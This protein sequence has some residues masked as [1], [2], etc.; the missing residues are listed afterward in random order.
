MRARSARCWRASTWPAARLRAH[1]WTIRAASRGGAGAAPE[2]AALPRRGGRALLREEVDFQARQPPDALAARRDPR[3]S[4][5][6]Q[7]AVRGR[8]HRGRH[9]LLFR[10]H[11]RAA[12]RRRHHRQRLVRRARTA[13]STTARARALLD[14]YRAVRPFTAAER[15][16]WPAMLRA[17]ALRFWVS[18][19][20]DF[21]LPRPG[22]ADPRQGPGPFPAHPARAHIAARRSGCRSWRGRS[23]TA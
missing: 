16:A 13:R 21:H 14:A 20:Y 2:I 15:D 10:L 4:V 17:G 8:A 3:R 5:P 1:A 23:Q 11:R 22:R 7:R 12:L 19:L 6:R 9:R 18:R